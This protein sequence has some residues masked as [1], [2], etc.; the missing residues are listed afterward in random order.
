MLCRAEMVVTHSAWTSKNTTHLTLVPRNN[1]YKNEDFEFVK[2]T[3][4][5]LA[6]VVQHW[7]NVLNLCIENAHRVSP[8][9]EKS[10][11]QK[12][13]KRIDSLSTIGTN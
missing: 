5:E 2:G 13:L 6:E 11:S 10:T 8:A 1:N 3:D 9:P 7:C 4:T 12:S